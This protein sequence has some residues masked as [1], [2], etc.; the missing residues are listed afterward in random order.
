MLENFA[1]TGKLVRFMLKRE[2]VISTLWILILVLFSIALAPGINAMFDAEGRAQFA[3]SFDNPVMIAM[4]GPVY[5][6]DNYTEGAMYTGM[7]LLWII[8]AV[9]IMNIF[10]VARHTRA[11]EEK[12][13]AEVVRSLP[14]GRLANLNATMITAVI[15]NAALGLLMGLGLAAMGV[16]NMGFAGSLLFGAVT[17]A[18]GLAF[19]AL[20]ALFCQLSSSKSGATGL[21]FL[22]LGLFYMMRAAGDMNGSEILSCI[23]PLGLILRAQAYI[24]NHWWPVFV[25][26][27]AGAIIS[28]AA[29]KLNSLRDLDQG[30][31]SARPGKKEASPLLHSNFGLAFRLLRN[32]LIIWLIVMFVLGASY[33]SII[34]DISIFVGDSPQYLEILGMPAAY[35][36]TLTDATKEAM[37]Q[38]YF[39]SFVTSMMTL[40]CI[41]P[42]LIAALKPRSEEKE[43]HTEHVLARA[44]PR[45]KYLSGYTILAYAASILLPCATATGIYISAAALTGDANPFPLGMLLKAN[46]AYLPAMWVMIGI[47][48]LLVGLL[49]KA[50]TAIWWYYGFVFFASF[51]GEVIGLPEWLLGLAP[52]KH[53]SQVLLVDINYTPL[54][55]MTLIAAVLTAT[56]LIFY[57]KRDLV[58]A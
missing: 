46:L 29:Y 21:S 41:V 20:T 43:Q 6:A 22:S 26:L 48:V 38:K 8:I 23:S 1:N 10:L 25:L 45:L 12:G 52:L 33:G 9:A 15:V 55:I 30:F 51:M 34:G 56:G 49:P 47:T 13:R 54:I 27:L 31:I 36:D 58:A 5:G 50:S 4:M 3:A 17:C 40:I 2:A 53:V 35:I 18:A 16:T 42:L 19:A 39:M 11:D 24:E 44:V 32:T 57:R 14:V 28:T 37:V 7:M